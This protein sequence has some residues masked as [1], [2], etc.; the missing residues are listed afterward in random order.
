[1]NTF[2]RL[3][4]LLQRAE[5]SATMENMSIG[6]PKECIEIVNGAPSEIGIREHPNEY[7]RR[8]TKLYRETWLIPQIQAALSIIEANEG[9]LIECERLSEAVESMRLDEIQRLAAAG[10]GRA[11]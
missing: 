7:I 1:M 2:T 5:Q 6:F 9:L 3:K 10:L 8:K 4:E 11:P